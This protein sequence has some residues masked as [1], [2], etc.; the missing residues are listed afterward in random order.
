MDIVIKSDERD[1][2]S[3]QNFYK[4]NTDIIIEHVVKYTE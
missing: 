1:D 4:I 2:R 3:K